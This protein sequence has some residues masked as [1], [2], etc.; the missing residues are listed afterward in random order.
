MDSVSRQL[1]PL[2]PALVALEETGQTVAA[3]D[4]LQIPQSTVSRSL[5]R[6]GTVLGTEVVERVGR[7][8]RLTEAGTALAP[9]ARAALTALET[10]V[11]AVRAQEPTAR[12]T[13]RLAFQGTLGERVVPSLVRAFLHQHPA[14]TVELS[15][16]SRTQCLAAAREREADICLVSPLAEEPELTSFRLHTEPLYLVVPEGHRL[17]GRNHVSLAEAGEEPFISMKN[18]YGMRTLLEQ[19]AAQAGFT[20]RIGFMGDDLTTL[21]GLVSARLGVCLAPRDPHGAPGCVEVPLDDD[22]SVREIGA[23]WRAGRQGSVARAFQELLR[24]SGRRL[25]RAGLQPR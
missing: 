25:T 1:L 17:A 24:H 19:L 4:L 9:H 6:I 23:C 16:L 10:G 21:R 11:E 14:V 13:L 7:G 22:A 15:Q 18:G 3:A 20:P 8:V 2:L 12:G 5:A